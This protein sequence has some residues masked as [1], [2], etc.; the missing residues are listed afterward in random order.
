MAHIAAHSGR[1][2]HERTRGIDERT[3]GI[4]ERT[5]RFDERTQ[6]P[7]NEPERTV[8]RR[9]CRKSL[10]DR[11]LASRDR[12]MPELRPDRSARRRLWMPNE[13]EPWL[14]GRPVSAIIP[15]VRA[16][17]MLERPAC[18]WGEEGAEVVLCRAGAASP[19]SGIALRP[20]GGPRVGCRC[21]GSG[22]LVVPRKLSSQRFSSCRT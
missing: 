11:G 20:V 13:P 8:C 18:R 21:P 17:S 10:N 15:I 12:L 7:A 14:T 22:Q 2:T 1:K 3:Q 19:T 4:D 5:Q 16:V 9:R 6:D